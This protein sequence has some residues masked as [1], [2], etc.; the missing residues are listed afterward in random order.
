MRIDENGFF[1]EDVIL[2]DEDNTPNNCIETKC[3]EGF[4]LPRWNGK[5]WIEGLTQAEID[6]IK[7]VT[8]EPTLEE[9]INALEMLELERMFSV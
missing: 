5:E 3:P 6:K 9:R 8:Q 1:L 2:E 4:Y 7:N